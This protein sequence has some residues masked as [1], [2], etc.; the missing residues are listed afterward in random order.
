[1]AH[2]LP[3]LPTHRQPFGRFGLP[4]D[5]SAHVPT[6]LRGLRGALGR[7]SAAWIKQV[8][9]LCRACV[10]KLGLLPRGEK[11]HYSAELQ[12]VVRTRLFKGGGRG[13][14]D[15]PHIGRAGWDFP[16]QRLWPLRN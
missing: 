12:L 2:Q 1:L 9:G 14:V 5:T 3:A 11:Q 7:R 15:A 8:K 4:S 16:T 10:R 6:A 13:R